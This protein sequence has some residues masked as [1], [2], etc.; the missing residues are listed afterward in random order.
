[1]MER[2]VQALPFKTILM[3]FG[4]QRREKIIVA[5]GGA[6]LILLLLLQLVVF[7]VIDRRARLTA[8]I[9]TGTETLK[10]IEALKG[11]YL[12]LT[13]TAQL[14]DSRI[15]NRS[16]DF[17]LFSF[18][19]ALAGQGGIKQSIAYMKPSTTNLKNSSYTLS[20]VEMKMDGLTTEQLTRF[21]HGLEASDQMI[22]I[23][24]LSIARGEKTDSLL[25]AVLQVETLA[26]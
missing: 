5:V 13:R 12:N 3:K 24:R 23:K 11:E 20:S 10:R 19:E 8:R 7:P 2:L 18:L 22:W 4:L 1:M 25:N 17:T 15:K 9:T 26:Q 6:T 16:G 14:N 21:M